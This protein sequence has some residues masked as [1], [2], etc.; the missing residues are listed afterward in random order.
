MSTPEAPIRMS[1]G[2]PVNGSFYGTQQG[3]PAT[4]SVSATSDER[5]FKAGLQIG[6]SVCRS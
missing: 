3:D 4:G 1:T 5:D 2:W 6:F